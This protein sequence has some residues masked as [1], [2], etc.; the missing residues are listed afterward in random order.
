MIDRPA[1]QPT[2]GHKGFVWKKN[3]PII[4]IQSGT[5]NNNNISNTSQGI[6]TVKVKASA[7]QNKI[8]LFFG[9]NRTNM[10]IAYRTRDQQMIAFG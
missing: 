1:E 2:D 8:F 7:Q 4:T 6:L 5:Y 10:P 3:F 9:A